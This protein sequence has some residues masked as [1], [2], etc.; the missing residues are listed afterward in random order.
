MRCVYDRDG[1]IL[2]LDLHQLVVAVPPDQLSRIPTI[3]AAAAGPDKVDPIL[4]VLRGRIVNILITDETT[5]AE[6]LRRAK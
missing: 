4:G 2:P 3:V 1:Q 6:L 5:A